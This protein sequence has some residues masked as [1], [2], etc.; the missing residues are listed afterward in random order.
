MP[1]LRQK[2]LSSGVAIG[3]APVQTDELNE[4]GYL[5]LHIYFKK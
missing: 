5:L 4:V 1:D 3:F 2:Q